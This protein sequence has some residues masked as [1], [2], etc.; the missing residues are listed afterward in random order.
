MLSLI[1]SLFLVCSHEEHHAVEQMD[2]DAGNPAEEIDLP[3]T[4]K[5]G[6]SLSHEGGEF[7]VFQDL[8][9]HIASAMG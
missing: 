4:G 3:P 2:I 6:F 9:N 1:Q 5:E 7:E 8:T